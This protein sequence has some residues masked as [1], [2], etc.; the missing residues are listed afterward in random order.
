MLSYNSIFLMTLGMNARMH[1]EATSMA[2]MLAINIANATNLGCSTT[3][4]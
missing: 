1:Q 2:G 4:V 3:E